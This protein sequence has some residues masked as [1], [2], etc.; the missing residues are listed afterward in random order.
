MTKISVHDLHE[1]L[2][3]LKSGEIILDVRNPDEYASGHMPSSLNIPL[4]QL[5]EKLEDLKKYVT[6]YV[7]CKMGGRAQRAAELLRSSGFTNIV[8]IAEL[9]MDAWHASGYPTES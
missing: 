9:G 2:H 5:P 3:E 1:K 7:H 6:I 4:G 8:C